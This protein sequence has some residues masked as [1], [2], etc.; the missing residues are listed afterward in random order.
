MEWAAG[1]KKIHAGRVG[2]IEARGG[3]DDAEEDEDAP[4]GDGCNEYG[5]WQHEVDAVAV[6]PVEKE[7]GG[8]HGGSEVAMTVG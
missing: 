1:C 8:F 7:R 3:V 5:R 6:G 2:A 4:V